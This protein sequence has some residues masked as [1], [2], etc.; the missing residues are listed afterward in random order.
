MIQGPQGNPQYA[1]KDKGVIDSGCSRHMI[2]N[3]SYLLDFQELNGGYVAFGGNLKGG[4]ILG[5]FE[6]KVDEGF[7]VG[8]SV[9]SKAF[10]V[11]NSRTRIVQET[12]HVNFLENKS[13]VAGIG[14]KWLFDIDCLTRTMNYQPV[15]AGNQTNPNAGCQETFYADKAG[16]EAN[17]QYMLFLVWSTGFTNPQ[18]K[19]GDATFDRKEHDAEK[20][21]SAVNF[22][23]SRN[24]EDYSKDSSNDVSAAGPIVP[25]TGQNYSNSTN[26]VSAA[27]LSNSNTSLTHGKSSL[28]DAYQPPDMVER[29]DSVYSDHQNVGAEANFNNLETYI[30]EEL[31]QFRMQ[32]VWI[33]VDL[34]LRKRAIGLQVKQKKDGIFISQD[35]YVAEILKK[36]RL[37]EGKSASTP[38]VTEKPLLMDPDGED[39]DFWRTVAVKSSN[40]VTRLQALDDKKKVVVTEAA[41]KDTLHLDD[42][43]GVDCLPNEEIFIELAR[44]GYEKPQEPEGQS[45]AEE[46]GGAEEQGNADNA[47]EEP[48]TAILED[49]VEDQSIPLPTLLTPPPQQPQDIPS[50]S[51]AQSPPPQP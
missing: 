6:G 37:T 27:G 15:T 50:T 45:D 29:E 30:T 2:G 3:M 47:A 44:M 35:K 11:F 25:T 12:L 26:P 43:E 22:S 9:N 17:Q 36:F 33:L 46:Q 4:N 21:E 38:I 13:N 31:L 40:D 1:L 39:V 49:D 34:P 20:H 48:V 24:F 32:I 23:P 18:N 10:R 16:D 8:Y 41:I 19:E 5:K 7:L 42:A 14:P 28:R 51:Q